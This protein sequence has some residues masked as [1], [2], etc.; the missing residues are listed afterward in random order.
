MRNIPIYIGEMKYRTH[1]VILDRCING[2][3]YDDDVNYVGIYI[4]CDR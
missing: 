4:N 2:D 3:Q 1:K